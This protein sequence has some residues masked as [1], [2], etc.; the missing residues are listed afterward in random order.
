MIVF[1]SDDFQVNSPLLLRPDWVYLSF[2]HRN[3][4][5][6]VPNATSVTFNPGLMLVLPGVANLLLTRLHGCQLQ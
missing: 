6:T 4:V 2:A 1:L 3:T 5:Q